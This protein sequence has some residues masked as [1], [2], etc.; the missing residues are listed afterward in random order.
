MLDII[1]LEYKMKKLNNEEE[2]KQYLKIKAQILKNELKD[3]L[4]QRLKKDNYDMPYCTANHIIEN[5]IIFDV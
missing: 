2:Y 5:Y 3:F 4:E 1:K